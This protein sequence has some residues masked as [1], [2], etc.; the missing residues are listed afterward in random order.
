MVGHGFADEVWSSHALEGQ[1]EFSVEQQYLA[2][3]QPPLLTAG[4]PVSSDP[5]GLSVQ[6]RQ[7]VFVCREVNVWR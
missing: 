2:G 6:R 1:I 5:P 3:T 4:V 7:W